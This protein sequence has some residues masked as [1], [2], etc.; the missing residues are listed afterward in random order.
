[1]G[2]EPSF[3]LV[4]GEKIL[5]HIE[6]VDYIGVSYITSGSGS[7]IGSSLTGEISM[8]TGFFSSKQVKREGSVFDAKSARIYLT[9]KRIVACNAK[10]ETAG[11]PFS[12]IFFNNIK[13]VNA[14]TKKIL[15]SS[16]PTIDLSLVGERGGIDNIKIAFAENSWKNEDRSKERDDF[17]NKIKR[18]LKQ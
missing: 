3:I 18:N 1:M 4:K 15:F 5:S 13:G 17:L 12:E 14:G 6:R 16:F 7:A 11:M 9:N 8:G 2:E 10:G